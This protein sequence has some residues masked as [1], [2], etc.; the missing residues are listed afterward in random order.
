MVTTRSATACSSSSAIPFC[1]ALQHSLAAATLAALLGTLAAPGARAASPH[2]EGR[3]GG[4]PLVPWVT[5]TLARLTRVQVRL[6]A[7]SSGAQAAAFGETVSAIRDGGQWQLDIVEGTRPMGAGDTTVAEYVVGGTTVCARSSFTVPRGPFLCRRAPRDAA[8]FTDGL[9]PILNVLPPHAGRSN[10]YSYVRG[11]TARVRG[12][13]CDAY[14]YIVHSPTA[15]ERGTLYLNHA[16][17]APCAQ[18]A[19]TV[20]P[21]LLGLGPAGTPRGTATTTSVTVWSRFND[22]TLTIPRVPTPVL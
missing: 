7:T 2:G 16:T 12:L 15:L 13:R 14:P 21:P 1:R 5:A 18:D 11:G 20:G 6:T 4:A 9:L 8:D 22:P 17:G 19:T 3:T 10:T